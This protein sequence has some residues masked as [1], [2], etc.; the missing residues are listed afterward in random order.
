MLSHHGWSLEKALLAA[1]PLLTPDYALSAPSLSKITL[2]YGERK[3]RVVVEQLFRGHEIFYNSKK[4]VG[5]ENPSF[6]NGF[7]EVDVWIPSVKLALEYQ[8][9]PPPPPLLLLTVLRTNTIM[10]LL[11]MQ[12][13]RWSGIRREIHKNLRPYWRK[14]M[15]L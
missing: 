1:Y 3:F 14:G 9:S 13:T 6:Q 5:L 12:T 7:Y 8:V 11:G 15:M 10:S 2:K 4:I